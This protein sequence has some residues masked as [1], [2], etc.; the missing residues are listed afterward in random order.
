[1]TG[2]AWYPVAATGAVGCSVVYAVPVLVEGFFW[3]A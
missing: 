1:M 3:R 2:G